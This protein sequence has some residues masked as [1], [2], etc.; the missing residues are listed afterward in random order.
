MTIQLM[1]FLRE[2]R[3]YITAS[4]TLVVVLIFLHVIEH[5]IIGVGSGC[6]AMVLLVLSGTRTVRPMHFCPG[7]P[8]LRVRVDSHLIRSP[9][10][11]LAHKL[12]LE[13]LYQLH[14]TAFQTAVMRDI[15][16]IP[17]CISEYAETG[18]DWYE[19]EQP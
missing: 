10:V 13:E 1:Q 19:E 5:R 16:Q 6:S 2:C 8:A 4:L 12:R 11:V 9:L 17:L 15:T 14:A 3:L 7:L 18:D